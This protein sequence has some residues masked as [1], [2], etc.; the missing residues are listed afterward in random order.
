MK[1]YEIIP[2]AEIFRVH[3][4]ANFGE[5]SKRDVV[6]QALLKCACGYSSG[7]TAQMIFAEHGLTISSRRKGVSALTQRGR[8]YLWATYGTENL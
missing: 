5:I 3:A 2:D 8:K 1:P 4:N 6:A 7:H